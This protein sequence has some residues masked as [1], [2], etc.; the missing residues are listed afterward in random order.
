MLELNF[1]ITASNSL[2]ILK[3][4]N[5]GQLLSLLSLVQAGGWNYVQKHAAA[6]FLLLLFI[7]M[8]SGEALRACSDRIL[9]SQHSA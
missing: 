1:S 6:K 8:W 5:S 2:Q 4:F 7:L 9:C 3:A